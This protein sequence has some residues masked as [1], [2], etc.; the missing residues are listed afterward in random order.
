MGSDITRFCSTIPHDKEGRQR[1]EMSME[2]KLV[3]FNFGTFM[4]NSYLVTTAKTL[5][6]ALELERAQKPA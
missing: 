2:E 4:N 6:E 5:G 1:K 3:T